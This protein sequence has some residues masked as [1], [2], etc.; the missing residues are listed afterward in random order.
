MAAGGGLRGGASVRRPRGVSGRKSLRRGRAV[1]ALAPLY[2]L[3]YYAVEEHGQLGGADLQARWSVADGQRKAKDAFLKALL[4]QAP[5][6]LRPR[7][8][9]EAIARTVTEDEPVPERGSSPRAWRTRALRP[10]KDL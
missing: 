1:I 6:I 2:L 5:A 3:Q 9:L 8:D 7:E 10:S 4:P